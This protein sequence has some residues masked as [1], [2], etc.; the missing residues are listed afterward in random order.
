MSQHSVTIHYAQADYYD[1]YT[2]DIEGDLATQ[3]PTQQPAYKKKLVRLMDEQEEA[4]ADWLKDNT[5]LYNKGKSEYQ[6]VDKKDTLWA[7]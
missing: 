3:E 5:V 4:M 1:S 7:A 2:Q 6:D